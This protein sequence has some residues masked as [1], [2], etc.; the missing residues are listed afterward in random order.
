ME[1]TANRLRA[2]RVARGWTIM[3]LAR[4]SGVDDSI[5]GRWERGKRQPLVASALAVARALG[6]PLEEIL[7]ASVAV[8]ADGG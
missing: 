4:R 8:G 2:L 7:P 3:E 1:A 6:V 5:I